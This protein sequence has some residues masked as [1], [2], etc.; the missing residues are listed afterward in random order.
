MVATVELVMLA[1][2]A[3]IK[4]GK[5]ARETYI[6]KTKQGSVTLPLPDS[7]YQPTATSAA[8]YFLEGGKGA[9]YRIEGSRVDILVDRFVDQRNATTEEETELLG[10]FREYVSRDDKLRKNGG[11]VEFQDGSKLDLEYWSAI[12]TVRQ[13]SRGEVKKQNR[14]LV[15]RLMGTIIEVGIDY[16][17]S[18]PGAISKESQQGKVLAAFVD[19]L[20]EIPFAE[21]DYEQGWLEELGKSLLI[22]ALETVSEQPELVSGDANVQALVKVTTKSLSVDILA[23]LKELEG[24]NSRKNNLKNWSEL[25]FRSLLTSAGKEVVN[26]PGQYLGVKS[27][28]EAT[29]IA[30]VGSSMIDITTADGDLSFYRLI[31]RDGLDQMTRAALSA[32]GEHPEL[33]GVDGKDPL[34][35]ILSDVV[36]T[37]S[38]YDQIIVRGMVP[39]I[40]RLVLEKTGSHLDLIWPGKEKPEN[41]LL[42]TAAKTS[43]EILTEKGTGRWKPRFS[44]DNLLTVTD[45]VVDELAENPNWL[46]SK[47]AG[48]NS[49]LKAALKESLDVLR[50]RADER[51]SG[52]V[53]VEMLKS[54]LSGAVLRQEFV[55]KISGGGGE[56]LIASAMDAILSVI[57]DSDLTGQK[58]KWQLFRNEALVSV[59]DV[60]L[61]ALARSKVLNAA[62]VGTLKQTLT[63]QVERLAQGEPLDLDALAGEIENNLLNP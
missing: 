8:L 28:P 31:G 58:A 52:E 34:G 55:K 56:T 32:V 1:I 11:R 16:F 41:H 53:A 7:F 33:V 21:L 22:A 25:V 59:V 14:R 47:A 43:L 26:N 60:S 45:A 13:F 54:A 23:R 30:K 42:L 3:G 50:K 49:T 24:D 15:H 40:T 12:V 48:V 51:L 29:L 27:K 62:A 5:V 6:V 2:R 9:K 4:L 63:E 39:E 19:A 37:L 57:F 10:I 44:R 38:E 20:D 17:A 61:A 46:L 36:T 35:I 18:V